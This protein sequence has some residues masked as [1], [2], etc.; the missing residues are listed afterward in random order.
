MATS[1]PLRYSV[2]FLGEFHQEQMSCRGR[3]RKSQKSAGNFVLNGFLRNLSALAK[4]CISKLR[5]GEGH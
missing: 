4:L 1:Q 5:N 3:Q 2:I